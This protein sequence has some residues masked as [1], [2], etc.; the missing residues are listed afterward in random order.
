MENKNKPFKSRDLFDKIFSFVAVGIIVVIA[1]SIVFGAFFF[2]IA[3]VFNLL[4]VQYESWYSFL[5]FILLFWGIGF[6][7]DMIAIPMIKVLSNYI[8]NK[9]KH[10]FMTFIIDCIFMLFSL[11]MADEF[12]SS[13]TIPLTTE[14]ITVIILFMAEY[15]L[16]DEPKNKN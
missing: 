3:G 12:M 14:L 9:Y 11:H 2:G 1:I 8:S 13:I 4:G 5:L 15:A 6:I 16:D 10:F 7:A